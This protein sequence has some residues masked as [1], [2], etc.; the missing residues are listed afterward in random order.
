MKTFLGNLAPLP[1]VVGGVTHPVDVV[2]HLGRTRRFGGWANP[3]WTVLHHLMLTTMLYTR[4]Y[5]PGSGALQALFHDGHEFIT[6]DIPTPVKSLL[7]KEEVRKLEEHLDIGI[8]KM[9]FL[10]PPTDDERAHV[11]ACDFAA[12]IIESYYFGNKTLDLDHIGTTGW[13][14]L[15]EEDQRVIARIVEATCPE[16]Y[17]EMVVTASINKSWSTRPWREK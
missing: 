7:G 10:A 9:L 2:F 15:S 13:G 17:S 14:K 3:E 5:G 16:V 6:G 8:R 12:L 4:V 11:K 1:G